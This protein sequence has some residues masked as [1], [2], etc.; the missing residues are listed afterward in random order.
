MKFFPN[1]KDDQHC[2][3]AS[4]L[5]VASHFFPSEKYTHKDMESIVDFKNHSWNLR[6]L[7]WLYQ[8]D[9]KITYISDFDYPA[10]AREGNQYLQ[11]F[12][13]PEVYEYQKRVSNF[14]GAQRETKA[15]QGKVSFIIRRPFLK[16]IDVYFKNNSNIL[17]ASINPRAI[18]GKDGYGNH[19]VVIESVTKTHITYKDPGL[20]PEPN[21]KAT[22]KRFKKALYELIVISKK[23]ELLQ[24]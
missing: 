11:W 13:R 16:D 7:K 2:F 3:P 21:A 23:E 12:W 4:L 14:E 9:L 19:T 8:K 17:L 1:L 18:D 6:G 15:L 20:P 10:F 24:K 5:M 22:R